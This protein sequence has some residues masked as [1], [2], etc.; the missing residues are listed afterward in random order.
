M[1]GR[2]YVVVSPCRD[3]AK[4]LQR[5]VDAIVRQTELPSR[6]VLVDDGSSDETPTMLRAFADAHEWATMLS[7]PRRTQRILGAGVIR[8]F[9]AGLAT[10]DLDDYDY[11]CK[12]DV[13]LDLPPGYFAGLMN[14]MEADPRLGTASGNPYV[15]TDA[16]TRDELGSAEMSWGMSKFYRVVAF[17]EIGGF[18]P[19][20]M[21]DGIDCHTSRM[22]GWR[23]RS[24]EDPELRFEHLRP[25]GSSDKSILR[26]RRRHGYGQYYMGTH[27]VFLLASAAN[28]VVDRPRLIGSFHILAGYANAAV[29]R[30]P[31]HGTA[32][33]RR[34]LRRFQLDSLL[35]G[36]HTATRRWEAARAKD[37]SGAF[38]ER[39]VAYLISRF[40][41]MSHAFIADEIESLRS[42]GWEVTV[43]SVR[44]GTPGSFCEVPVTPLSTNSPATIVRDIAMVLR[45]C[46]VGAARVLRGALR[47]VSGRRPR[48]IGAAYL[49]EAAILL[50]ELD[51]ADVRHVHVHFANNAAEIARL[52][53]A[54]DQA[55]GADARGLTW[56]LTIHGLW[57]HGMGCAESPFPTR[58]E[59]RFGRLGDK[60][61]DASAVAVID[62]FARVHVESLLA[63]GPDPEVVRMG[64][65]VDTFAPSV[66]EAVIPR[67]FTVLTVGRLVREKD[68]PTLL[69]AFAIANPGGWRLRVVGE[70]PLENELRRHAVDLGLN[71]SVDFLGRRPR[72]EL[73]A[74]YRTADLLAMSSLSEGI[75]TVLM[76]AMACGVPVVATRVGGIPEL[77]VEGTGLL[78]EAGDVL[79]LAAAFTTIADD[80]E[81]AHRIG[82][83]A[84]TQVLTS[85]DQRERRSRWSRFLR[86]SIAQSAGLAARGAGARA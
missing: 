28:R 74:L 81:E 14:R 41:T 50:A 34:Q 68:L 82:A 19:E 21:W 17:K 66:D 80:P 29:R 55:K 56:S 73:P 60:L 18:V 58:D 63:G 48:W 37:W 3:E 83:R 86:E 75:P 27:P 10:I 35:F 72:D 39:K 85:F 69:E 13:D 23:A 24:F 64:V 84:R 59:R 67:P 46:P 5:T 54:L 12:L 65:D 31:R 20:L 9:D 30:I 52:A 26:G 53:C 45:D 77:V 16:G 42:D 11:V 38:P 22:L 6:W 78:V 7:L 36:K 76:E 71:K 2:R 49:V 25:E 51:R 33:F 15:T 43:V 44:P 4:Y 32:E 61:R 8:A 40:P 1:S 79:G 57:M 47:P 70:G 62:D